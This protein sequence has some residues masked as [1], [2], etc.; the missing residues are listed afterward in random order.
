MT[1]LITGALFG[2][3]TGLAVGAGWVVRRHARQD[4]A[5]IRQE[6]SGEHP[7]IPATDLEVPAFMAQSGCR[8]PLPR[9]PTNV[10]STDLDEAQPWAQPTTDCPEAGGCRRPYQCRSGCYWRRL[11]ALNQHLADD[12]P[13]HTLPRSLP[14]RID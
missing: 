13:A 7:T 9:R 6:L 5:E 3:A 10:R 2:F 4:E 1:A 8:P 12:D 14:G 11:D